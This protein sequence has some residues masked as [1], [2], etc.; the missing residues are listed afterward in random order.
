MRQMA[1]RCGPRRTVPGRPGDCL[2]TLSVRGDPPSRAAPLC[3]DH[4][5]VILSPFAPPPRPLPWLLRTHRWTS[6]GSTHL[7]P[8]AVRGVDLSSGIFPSLSSSNMWGVTSSI[9]LLHLS[10]S[11]PA[12]RR[13]SRPCMR[14]AD[15]SFKS[16]RGKRPAQPGAALPA[17]S[18][19]GR[20]PL[21]LLLSLAHL[22]PPRP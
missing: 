17:A 7:L 16:S 10:R 18:P 2:L 6:R 13:P 4:D 15:L 5:A 14:T 21:P 1:S 8:S 11:G 22:F 19:G 9:R 12:A 20:P 3:R